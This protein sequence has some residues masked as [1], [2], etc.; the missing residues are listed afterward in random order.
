MQLCFANEVYNILVLVNSGFSC[1]HYASPY[2]TALK[3]TAVDNQLIGDGYITHQTI[4]IT[5]QVRPFHVEE[6]VLYV[7]FTSESI[8][9]PSVII[10]PLGWDIMK[11][12]TD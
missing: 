2:T 3:D 12:D 1:Q 9:L 5:L 10:A 6:L 8:L 11:R 7:L 4:P